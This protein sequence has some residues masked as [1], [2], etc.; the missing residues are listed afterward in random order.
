MS[1]AACR[2]VAGFLFAWI[3]GSL[4]A[5]AGDAATSEPAVHYDIIIQHGQVVDGTG[6]PW[7]RADIGIHEGMITAIGRLQPEAA[8]QVIDASGWVVAPGFIDMMGQ[9]ATPMLEDPDTALNL[10]TQGITTINAGEGSSAAPLG[11]EQ[12]LR[13]GWSTMAEYFQLIDLKG[14]PVNVAQSVGHTQIRRLVMGDEDRRPSDEELREMENWVREAMRA[15]AIGVST[16]LIYPPAIYAQ[17]Q[18]IAALAKVAG[19]HGGRYYTHMRNEGDLLLEAIDE[20]IEIGKSASTPVHIFHLKAAGQQNWAKMELA[21][22]RIQAA[23]AEGQQITADVYPYINNGLSITALVHPRHFAAGREAFF[24]RLKQADQRAEIRQEMENLS[25]WENWY[26]HVGRD[27][28]KIV[29]GQASDR[30]YAPHAGKTLAD[31]AQ[32]CEE[33]PWETFFQLLQSGAFVLPQSMSEANV[34][35]AIQQ[36]FVSF[37]TDVGPSG[38]AGLAS[39]PRAFGALPRLFSRYVRELGAIPLEQAVSQASS[40]AANE[41]M[42]FDR[43]RIAIGQAADIIAFDQDQFVDRADFASPHE[44]AE[45]MKFVIVNGE[46]VLEQGELTGKRPGRVL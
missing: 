7:Y 36:P 16:A 11:G 38:G 25:G 20:A 42:A 21:L 31:I 40:V 44:L 27:W 9:S 17:T 46:V 1:H 29:V 10:L 2:C 14:L 4:P 35:R 43:G 6:A 26:R 33:Q 39:H 19:E 5:V 22:A 41:L 23:R 24:R 30:R 45:G 18:E 37:C 13:S 12:A 15:G 34:I 32:A 3:S 28:N 8:E